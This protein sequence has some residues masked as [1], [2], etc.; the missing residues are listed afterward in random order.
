[1]GSEEIDILRVVRFVHIRYLTTNYSKIIDHNYRSLLLNYSMNMIQK[2][3]CINKTKNEVF[4][5]VL[6]N[7]VY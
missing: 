5:N 3:I 7:S 1:M 6:S 2:M 4:I